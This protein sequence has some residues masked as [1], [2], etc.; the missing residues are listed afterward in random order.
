MQPSNTYIHDTI[1]PLSF[2]EINSLIQSNLMPSHFRLFFVVIAT[3]R[4]CLTH[5]TVVAWPLNSDITLVR[6]D[7]CFAWWVHLNLLYRTFSLRSFLFQAYATPLPPI[8]ASM[9]PWYVAGM[10][11]PYASPA[12]TSHHPTPLDFQ[13]SP[14][15]AAAGGAWSW[16]DRIRIQWPGPDFPR[17][18]HAFSTKHE[19]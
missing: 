4:T 1:L 13:N 16:F 17:F 3:G 12:I 2:A 19:D 7:P 5:A 11:H 14:P 6:P 9:I 18:P 15:F 8:L 10:Y